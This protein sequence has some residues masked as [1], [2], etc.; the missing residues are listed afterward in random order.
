MMIKKRMEKMAKEETDLVAM[1]ISFSLS[2][3]NS[4]VSMPMYDLGV[5]VFMLILGA[6]KLLF[7]CNLAVIYLSLLSTL[8][9]HI[10]ESYYYIS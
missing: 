6:I 1:A 10:Y 2:L 9:I 7:S 8:R 4:V 5:M 3:F